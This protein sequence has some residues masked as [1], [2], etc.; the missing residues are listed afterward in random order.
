VRTINGKED[1]MCQDAEAGDALQQ[2]KSFMGAATAAGEIDAK[3]KEMIVMALSLAVQCGPCSELHIKKSRDA[4]I[5]EAELEE[6]ASLATLF[7]GVKSMVL[8][9][10]VKG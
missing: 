7:G 1:V 2:F 8:W 3:T 5:T 6:L 4:G 10:K 9:N